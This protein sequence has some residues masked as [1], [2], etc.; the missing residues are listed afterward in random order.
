[1]ADP[2][3]KFVFR[4]PPSPKLR[5]PDYQRKLFERAAARGALLLGVAELSAD[6]KG[7]LWMTVPK[8]G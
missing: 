8:I 6:A 1:M 7:E 3:P 2:A 5:S 4:E